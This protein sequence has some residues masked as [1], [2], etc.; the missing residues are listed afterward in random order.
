M[1]RRAKLESMLKTAPDDPFLGYGL[2]LEMLKEGEFDAGLAQLKA[3][4]AQHPDYHAAY[5]QLG[6]M[7]A[8]EGREDEAREWLEKGIA[9]ATRVGDVHAAGEM[10]GFL[11]SL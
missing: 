2:A 10:D 5:F 9:A 1:S 6:Q 3:V 11:Q 4:A 7:L 8:R